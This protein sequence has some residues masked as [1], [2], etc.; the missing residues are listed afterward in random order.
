MPS[1][2]QDSPQHGSMVTMIEY[3]RSQG[4]QD[5]QCLSMSL[6]FDA[7]HATA[8]PSRRL[9]RGRVPGIRLCDQMC[10]L[11]IAG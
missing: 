9:A 7:S 11:I 1:G 4:T 8:S 2:L 10:M 6:N 5:Q 3:A